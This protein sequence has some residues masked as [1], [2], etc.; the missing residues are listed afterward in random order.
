MGEE[1]GRGK[2]ERV[3]KVMEESESWE[4]SKWTKGRRDFRAISIGLIKESIF[5][6]SFNI[7]HFICSL[8]KQ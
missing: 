1:N 2:C 7:W 3:R 5:Q 4:G 8:I 6:D